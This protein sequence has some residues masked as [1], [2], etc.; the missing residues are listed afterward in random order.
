MNLSKLQFKIVILDLLA[1]GIYTY[2][3]LP[4][5]R[6][7]FATKAHYVNSSLALT[8]AWIRKSTNDESTSPNVCQLASQSLF[9]E[10]WSS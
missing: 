3:S 9:S 8:P 4:N 2:C 6:Y 10:I 7:L 5:L 1:K